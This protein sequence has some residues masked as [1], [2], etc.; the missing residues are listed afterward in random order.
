LSWVSRAF[1]E[2]AINPGFDQGCRRFT[3]GGAFMSRLQDGRVQRY[4]RVIGVA[5]VALV[6]ALLWGCRRG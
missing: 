5:A 6:L 2:H 3:A 4:L 1:D